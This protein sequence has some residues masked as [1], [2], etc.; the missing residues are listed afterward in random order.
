[1]KSESVQ[2]VGSWVF[3]RKRYITGDAQSALQKVRYQAYS[4]AVRDAIAR[5]GYKEKLLLHSDHGAQYT[6]HEYRKL[7][8]EYGF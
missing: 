2:R 8:D 5:Y 3:V 1:M 6:S 7:L 4:A